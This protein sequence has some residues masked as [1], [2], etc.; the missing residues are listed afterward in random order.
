MVLQITNHV[1]VT[2]GALAVPVLPAVWVRDRDYVGV[3]RTA[4]ATLTGELVRRN[5][6][7][8]GD[9]TMVRMVQG[10]DLAGSRVG[11][12]QEHRSQTSDS[13]KDG[14]ESLINLAIL[15]AKSFAS[16]PEFAK[17]TTF[18]SG[19]KVEVSLFA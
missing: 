7:Q 15:S 9:M 18:N 13:P 11:P 19:G 2:A 14:I 17:K 6:D 16:D 5:I 12:A 4:L 10:D 8:A 3:L 1:F